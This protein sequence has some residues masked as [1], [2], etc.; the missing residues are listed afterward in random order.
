MRDASKRTR[1]DEAMIEM[2]TR[3]T[4]IWG[5]DSFSLPIQD[6]TSPYSFGF[7]DMVEISKPDLYQLFTD[8]TGC[9]NAAL[10]DESRNKIRGLWSG[11]Q[12]QS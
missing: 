5:K 1:S 10:S 4:G 12:F 8:S 3:E 11:Q 2:V 9:Q 7:H 6:S